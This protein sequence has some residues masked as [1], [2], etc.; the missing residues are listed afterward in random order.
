LKQGV[1]TSEEEYKFQPETRGKSRGQGSIRLAPVTRGLEPQ[2]PYLVKRKTVL[3]IGVLP[4]LLLE[5]LKG[6]KS[7]LR[8]RG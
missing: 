6:D 8:P 3:L 7:Y 1:V 2:H 4:P 5:I